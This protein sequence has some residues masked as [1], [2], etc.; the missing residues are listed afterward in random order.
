MSEHAESGAQPSSEAAESS[1]YGSV[2]STRPLPLTVVRR[3]PW[4]KWWHKVIHYWRYGYSHPDEDLLGVIEAVGDA[5]HVQVIT[6]KAVL[7]GPAVLEAERIKREL[8][9][10]LS[11]RLPDFSTLLGIESRINALYPP[12]LAKRRQ[13]VIRDRFERVAPPATV[14][15][16]QMTQLATNNAA[17][18]A[19]HGGQSASEPEAG[20]VQPDPPAGGDG[21]GGN[22]GNGG[23]EGGSPAP[24]PGEAS[25]ALDDSRTDTETL[26]GYIHANYLMTIGREKAVRDLKRWLLMRFWLFL[27]CLVPVLFAVWLILW[28]NDMGE[29]WGLLLG[30]FLIATVG[31]AGATTSVI[32]RLQRAISDN[33]LAADPIIELTALRTGKNEISMALLSSSIFAL[34]MWA[35]FASDVPRMVGFDGGLFPSAAGAAAPAATVAATPADTG[36]GEDDAGDKP[37][38]ANETS[39]ATPDQNGLTSQSDAEVGP[40]PARPAATPAPAAAPAASQPAEAA[41]IR[42]QLSPEAKSWLERAEGEIRH[43]EHAYRVQMAQLTAAG[44]LGNWFERRRIRHDARAAIAFALLRQQDVIAFFEE[45]GRR[46]TA[47][48]RAD[49]ARAWSADAAEAT[50]RR[51]T[52]QG[53]RDAIDGEA[54]PTPSIACP[55]GKECNPFRPLATQLRLN[56]ETDFFK[57][58]LW[59][60]IAGFAERFVPDML[61]RVVTRSRGATALS[62]DSVIA[63]QVRAGTLPSTPAATGTAAGGEGQSGP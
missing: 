44:G 38:D 12:A 16:W 10:E 25:G 39:A 33:V 58:L 55:E 37:P 60:F 13:W 43:N 31:R 36:G 50:E 49:A 21:I 2:I 42:P 30:L 35:F 9:E 6:A 14:Q 57:M 56:D 40:A 18:D 47:A 62:S 1:R 28:S 7:I 48:N 24:P 52:L 29:Y 63:A 54:K 22:G 19:G 46:A 3:K 17:D 34:L 23:G 5:L 41:T 45:G 51:E 8:D 11:K 15:Y 53:L 32:R 4:N 26:L 59:A 61:D 27:L 20:A